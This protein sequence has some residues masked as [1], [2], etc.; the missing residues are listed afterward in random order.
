MVYVSSLCSRPSHRERQAQRRYA[1]VQVTQQVRGRA[2]RPRAQPSRSGSRQEG[3]RTPEPEELAAHRLGSLDGP[4]GF[5]KPLFSHR[6]AAALG[7][8]AARLL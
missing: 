6:R 7:P 5:S 3:A 8:A 2:R 1:H 4:L